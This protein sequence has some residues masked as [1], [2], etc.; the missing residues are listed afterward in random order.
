MSIF[1]IVLLESVLSTI[2][3]LPVVKL[4][5]CHNY[6]LLIIPQSVIQDRQVSNTSSP[7]AKSNLCITGN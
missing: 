3:Q 6:Y 7:S 2:T 4:L 5:N 1:G